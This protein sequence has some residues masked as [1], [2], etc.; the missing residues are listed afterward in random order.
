MHCIVI[1]KLWNKG[2]W[3]IGGYLHKKNTFE[4][5]AYLSNKHR[6]L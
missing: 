6:N 2:K 4:V 1:E 3:K 5:G